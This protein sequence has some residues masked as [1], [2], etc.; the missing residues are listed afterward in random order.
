MVEDDAELRAS[1]GEP[2]EGW[3]VYGAENGDEPFDIRVERVVVWN[4]AQQYG[5]VRL[6]CWEM[7]TYQG[8]HRLPGYYEGFC[9]L[10]DVEISAMGVLR[11]YWDRAEALRDATEAARYLVDKWTENLQQLAV[12]TP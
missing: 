4:T 2:R 7:F 11:V 6:T 12:Q 10:D 8:T 1:W 9:D 5:D 3:V